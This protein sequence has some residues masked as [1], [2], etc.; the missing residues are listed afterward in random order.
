MEASDQDWWIGMTL[1]FEFS[2]SNMFA[3]DTGVEWKPLLKL[4]PEDGEAKFQYKFR[5]NACF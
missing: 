1:F 4:I 2:I 3:F 5:S